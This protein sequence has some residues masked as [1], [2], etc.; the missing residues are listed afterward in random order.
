[1]HNYGYYL[2]FHIYDKF[3]DQSLLVGLLE[4]FSEPKPG[5]FAKEPFRGVRA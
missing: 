3:D 5:R 2:A 1:M 4:G